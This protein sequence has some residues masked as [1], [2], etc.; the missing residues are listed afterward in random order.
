MLDLFRTLPGL[1]TDIDGAEPVREAL[2][3]AAWR[4]IAGKALAEHTAPIKLEN[5]TLRV[6]VSNLTW[7]RHLKDLCGQMLFKI[8][9]VVGIP[10]VSFIE[11]EI[12]EP[13]VLQERSRQSRSFA[14]DSDLQRESKKEITPDLVSSAE[15]ITDEKLR[16][17]FLLAAGKCL[18]RKKHFESG[19]RR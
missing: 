2:V 11:L 6:A 14:S 15:K 18:V 19:E 10:A 13:A 17:Q 7:Q 12:N 4:R 1:V 9:A 8:N 5:G 3:F 16:E